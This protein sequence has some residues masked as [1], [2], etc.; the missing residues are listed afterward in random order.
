MGKEL[1]GEWCRC[2]L[3][4]AQAA[5][6][7]VRHRDAEVETS[8]RDTGRMLRELFDEGRGGLQAT[9]NGLQLKCDT[10]WVLVK[11]VH[12]SGGGAAFR[13]VAGSLSSEYA[14]EL[15]NIYE[16]KLRRL[17]AKNTEKGETERGQGRDEE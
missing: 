15:C 10:G 16:A 2:T 12:P 1:I 3:R 9:S 6:V 7:A 5:Y 4:E 11:P 8:W 14:D 17:K 13:V